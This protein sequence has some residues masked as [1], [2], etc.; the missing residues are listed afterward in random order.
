ML[1]AYPI[2]LTVEEEYNVHINNMAVLSYRSNKTAWKLAEEIAD[3]IVEKKRLLFL[4]E[5]LDKTLNALTDTERWLLSVK[6]FG[7]KRKKKTAETLQWQNVFQGWG[8]SRYFRMQNRLC[9]KVR[10]QLNLLGFTKEEFDKNYAQME[11]FQT[12]FTY[13]SK[14]QDKLMS[15]REKRCLGMAIKGRGRKKK[16]SLPTVRFHTA[17]DVGDVK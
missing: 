10:E 9:Q 11:L 2:L 6:Y 16:V 14:Q 17:D 13:L 8:E 7:K 1:Y 15:E 4:K 5:I 12:I 3:E